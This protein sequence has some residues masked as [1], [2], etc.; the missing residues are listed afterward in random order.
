MVSQALY[1]RTLAT[2][3]AITLSLLLAACFN[4]AERPTDGG[5]PEQVD[6]DTLPSAET[7]PRPDSNSC[8]NDKIDGTDECDGTDLPY[9]SCS[10]VPG[11]NYTGGTLSCSSTCKVDTS[12]CFGC[13]DGAVNP[14]EQCDGVELDSKTCATADSKY[15]GGKLGC[16]P[17]CNFDFSLCTFCGDGSKNHSSEQCDTSDVGGAT[18]ASIGQG[19]AKGALTCRQGCTFDTS[20]CSRCGNNK[21]DA[22]DGE[23][24]D[25]AAAITQTCAGLGFNGGGSLG[26]NN[27]TCTF[28]TSG[29]KKVACPNGTVDSGEECDGS[30]LDGKTCKTQGFDGGALSC[31][32]NC[33]F[34]TAGCYKCGDGKRNGTEACDG[35]DLA[36]ATCT[37]LLGS[38]Y[39]GQLG[40][41]G[42]CSYDTSLCYPCGVRC[43]VTFSVAKQGSETTA[44][45]VGSFS[46]TTWS[47][48][49][50][51]LSG[52]NWSITVL[53]DAAQKLEYRFVL[54][55]GKAGETSI[56]DPQNPEPGSSAQSSLFVNH[57]SKHCCARGFAGSSCSL[58]EVGH[59]GASCDQCETGYTM[60]AGSCLWAPSCRASAS[61][62]ID[63][64]LAPDDHSGSGSFSTAGTGSQPT[65]VD[66]YSGLEWRRCVAGM[67]WSGATCSGS[68]TFYRLDQA[69]SACSGSWGGHNDWRA[70]E[71]DEIESLQTYA[72]EDP[73]I[74]PTLFPALPHQQT[75]GLGTA[76][77]EP[78][79]TRVAVS[80]A[81]EHGKSWYDN[82]PLKLPVLCVRGGRASVARP[83]FVVEADDG[84]TVKDLWTGLVWRRCPLGLTYQSGSC[85]GTQSDLTFSAAKSACQALGSGWRMPKTRELRAIRRYC[86]KWSVDGVAFP[87][88]SMNKMWT[89]THVA[90]DTTRC[91]QVRT[92]DVY[93]STAGTTGT[94]PAGLGTM[95]VK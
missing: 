33:V 52:S 10:N 26:C 50:M 6:A 61:Y 68:A 89:S 7:M 5:S 18:C 65:V 81:L 48:Q 28:D 25:G 35:S 46:G 76:T 90:N 22:G 23:E 37:S 57:C 4:P 79:T 62:L 69:Q 63:G 53:L 49:A 16:G 92:S 24:C 29:C 70:P 54:D 42:G 80:V 95:C 93:V 66:K 88:P 43:P 40:C 51:T 77:G 74:D 3:C 60:I 45:L 72:R 83:R 19:F 1:P 38:S 27:S 47:S 84:S 9:A 41:T 21:V 94:T 59:T 36:S 56:A 15:N 91:Y 78:G 17:G 86:V 82:A 30:N 58:C 34:D 20:A 75:G 32:P 13:G 44:H 2:S 85:S 31:E 73:A 67:T 8:G 14:G 71:L 11:Q 64:S 87:S 12:Q 39:R 55:Q